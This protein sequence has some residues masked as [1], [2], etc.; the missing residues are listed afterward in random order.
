MA[1]GLCRFNTAARG[2]H[3]ADVRIVQEVRKP[4]LL[5]QV[6]ALGLAQALCDIVLDEVARAHTHTHT[7][8]HHALPRSSLL[9][10]RIWI[11][12][13]E[14]ARQVPAAQQPLAFARQHP[15]RTIF[16][17]AHSTQHFSC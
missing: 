5:S 4:L 9:R 7:P 16:P 13:A 12:A 6:V 11:R 17:K 10:L 1:A 8:T 3:Q 15:P 2:V 14:A